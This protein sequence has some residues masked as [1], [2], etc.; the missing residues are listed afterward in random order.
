MKKKLRGIL[1]LLCTISFL[2]TFSCGV[3]A[4]TP[5]HYANE[6]GDDGISYTAPL[7][8]TPYQMTTSAEKDGNLI[9]VLDPG[10]GGKDPGASAGGIYE[11][12][13]NLAVATYCKNFLEQ[14]YSGKVTVFLTRSNNSTSLELED[15][16]VVAATH[17]PDLMISLHFNSSTS[18]SA[19]GGEV[20]VSRLEEYALT[21]LGK[22]IVNNLGDL[23]LNKRGVFTRASESNTY[24]T[25]GTRLADY[26][27]IIK[28]PA[29]R[30]IPSMIV[31]HCFLSNASD[32]TFASSDAN[33][34]KLGEADAKAIVSYFNLGENINTTTLANAKATATKRLNDYYNDL[35]LTA[36]NA[37]YQA[38]IEQIYQ[39]ALNRIN[40]ATGTGKIN[41]TIN[42]AIET[43]AY[44]PTTIAK[45]SDVKA[46]DWY[47]NAVIYS[48][49]NGFF[50]GTSATTFSPA[51]SITRGMFI[52]VV[53]RTAGASSTTPASTVFSDVDSKAYYAPYIAW[54][55]SNHIIEGLSATSFGPNQAITREDLITILYRYAKEKGIT[56]TGDTG[57]TMA[58][59]SDGNTVDSWATEAMTWAVTHGVI[60]GDNQGKINPRAY[61]TRAEAAKIMMTFTKQS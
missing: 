57:K 30:E 42:R 5:D 52:T 19:N 56:L 40:L 3:L 7:T 25:D 28:H 11:R 59:F 39:D 27:G 23:G 36:Y 13:I 47:K 46:L 21:D 9:I 45:F 8:V 10:H 2:F 4:A 16:A 31:E 60:N 26:Y 35:T 12:E 38:K 61:T 41:L 43:I 20:Y 50:N 49:E 53:G 51:A 32:R 44:Y 33:L 18:S 6:E 24:W 1:T 14:N 34:K 48:V 22:Q 37:S 54:G 58:N 15:R 17:S 29:Y 55:Y